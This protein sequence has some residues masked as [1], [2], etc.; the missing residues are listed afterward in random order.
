MR[1]SAS[2]PARRAPATARF[3]RMRDHLP[4]AL[5]ALVLFAAVVVTRVRMTRSEFD[6][7]GQAGYGLAALAL[8]LLS[9]LFIGRKRLYGTRLG[10]LRPYYLL[11]LWAGAIWGPVVLLHAAFAAR[12]HV[13][14]ALA[15]C[16][17][18]A[19]ASG[20]LGAALQ[21]LTLELLL[22]LRRPSDGEGG[23]LDDL[24]AARERL[25]AEIAELLR[26]LAPEPRRQGEQAVAGIAGDLP[27]ARMLRDRRAF[28]QAHARARERLAD[29]G[30]AL[31]GAEGQT[32]LRIA[33]D[34]VEL[35]RTEARVVLHRLRHA[36][37]ALHFVGAAPAL[38][39]TAIHLA[40]VWRY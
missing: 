24:L 15:L 16:T 20:L 2:R 14:V 34:A 40:I 23:L 13:N 17:F 28:D 36:W 3:G 8:L 18:A 27:L 10:P 38:A 21:W 37:L 32:L 33:A 9:L 6:D 7:W 19:W 31:D 25:A 35:R 26:E 5:G 11:H 4:Y 30:S 39:L 12:G 1:S 22:R 29:R